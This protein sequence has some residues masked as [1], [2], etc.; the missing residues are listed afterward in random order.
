M[1]ELISYQDLKNLIKEIEELY[2]QGI[3]CMAAI[4][5]IK[6]KYKI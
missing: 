6:N 1:K 4:E 5:I 3:S 2:F